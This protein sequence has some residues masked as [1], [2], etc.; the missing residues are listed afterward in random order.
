MTELHQNSSVDMPFAIQEADKISSAEFLKEYILLGQDGS[1]VGNAN[2]TYTSYLQNN[3]VVCSLKSILTDFSISSKQ[4]STAI[5]WRSIL[6][7][8][9]S[10]R[11]FNSCLMQ[12]RV[13]TTETKDI[14]DVKGMGFIIDNGLVYF[15]TKKIAQ[16]SA[17]LKALYHLQV[18]EE[19][20]ENDEKDGCGPWVVE[21]FKIWG[22][23]QVLQGICVETPL[24]SP[25]LYR[26]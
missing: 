5:W 3:K 16:K 19:T 11:E 25:C 2:A 22:L 6:A 21:H 15:K 17:V 12:N 10:G 14:F 18:K 8:P 24:A 7:C 9:L 1:T 4:V 26:R 23:V 20:C 13:A